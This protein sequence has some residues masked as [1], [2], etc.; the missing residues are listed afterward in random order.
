MKEL[1]CTFLNLRCNRE[2]SSTDR[3]ALAVPEHR[4]RERFNVGK[5]KGEIF[6]HRLLT[7]M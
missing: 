5:N 6:V 4:H 2:F 1:L 3:D 7:V